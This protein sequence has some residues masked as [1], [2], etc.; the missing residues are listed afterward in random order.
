MP[1]QQC[2]ECVDEGRHSKRP[3]QA[4]KGSGESE[5]GKEHDARTPVAG[6][7][8]AVAPHEPPTLAALFLRQRDQQEHR[9]CI[10][11][12]KERE[13]LASIERGDD[14]RRPTTEL[15]P[16]AIQQNGAREV[17]AP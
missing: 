9:L 11:E 16:A 14:T 15:S 12:R 6:N 10:L 13:F 17:L 1:R 8:G 3:H 4:T 2:V 5:L 7:R